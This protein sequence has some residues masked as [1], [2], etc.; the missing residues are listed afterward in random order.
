MI[1]TLVE[2][3]ISCRRGISPLHLEPLYVERFGRPS[4]PVT[5]DVAASSILLPMFASLTDD[6]QA[7]VIEAVCALARRR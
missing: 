3:G 1:R 5:E 7:R 2:R 6:D 4:L